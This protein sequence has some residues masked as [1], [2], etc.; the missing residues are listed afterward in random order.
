MVSTKLMN[1]KKTTWTKKET[2]SQRAEGP[3]GV[4][5]ENK[6]YAKRIIKTN[7]VRNDEK[8]PSGLI[9]FLLNLH[10]IESEVCLLF[11]TIWTSLLLNVMT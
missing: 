6:R 5:M 9:T 3:L 4:I 11:L 2:I 8:L 7:V 1:K 10:S